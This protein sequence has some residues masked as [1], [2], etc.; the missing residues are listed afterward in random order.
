M[1]NG[2]GRLYAQPAE[3]RM[4]DMSS[5]ST[6]LNNEGPLFST[7]RHDPEENVEIA[8][9]PTEPR[10]SRLSPPGSHPRHDCPQIPPTV[11]R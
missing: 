11:R 5:L 4:V 1:L 3:V 9:F 2:T 8:C 7:N 10:E 6:Y